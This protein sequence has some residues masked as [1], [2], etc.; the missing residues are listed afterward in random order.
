MDYEG[1]LMELVVEYVVFVL[2]FVLMDI[3]V[4]FVFN[5]GIVDLMGVLEFDVVLR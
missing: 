4:V 3:D 5:E 1:L 2:G